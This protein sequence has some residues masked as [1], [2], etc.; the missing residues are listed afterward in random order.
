M[1]VGSSRGEGVDGVDQ[2]FSSVATCTTSECNL[3]CVFWSLSQKTKKFDSLDRYYFDCYLFIFIFLIV[4]ALTMRGIS[5][6]SR[7]KED[8]NLKTCWLNKNL[9]RENI[10]LMEFQDIS[11]KFSAVVVRLR[12]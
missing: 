8:Y 1:T 11:C 10:F 4:N 9:A 5:F 12:S 7:V 3:C 2:L 6:L